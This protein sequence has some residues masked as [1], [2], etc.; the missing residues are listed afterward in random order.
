MLNMSDFENARNYI[1]ARLENELSPRLT[2][3]NLQ[4]TLD[5]VVPAADLLATLEKVPDEDRLL[6]LTAAYFHDVGFIHQRDGHEQV[7]IQ[8]AK[9]NLPRFGYSPAQIAVIHGIIQATHLPQSPRTHLERIIADADMDDLGNEN[10]WQRS[11]D[12]RQELNNY[13]TQYTD[14]EWY[15]SQLRLMESHHYFTDSERLLRDAL[16]QQHIL[17]LK[18]LL[19]TGSSYQVNVHKS[20]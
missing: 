19:E 5:E 18:R 6:L 12:L 9:Q 3:H 7:G 11:N 16:K 4:H 1:L 17:E 10:F 2:Y 14:E 15:A 20:G 8:L 13:G